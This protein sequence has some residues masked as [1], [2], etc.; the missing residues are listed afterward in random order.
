MLFGT[1]SG[2]GFLLLPQMPVP[3]SLN[4]TTTPQQSGCVIITP[5]GG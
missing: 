3:P 2:K 1:Q 4:S 5:A